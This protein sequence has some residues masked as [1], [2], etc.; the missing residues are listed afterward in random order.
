MKGERL[1]SKSRILWGKH[2]RPS[3]AEKTQAINPGDKPQA[4]EAEGCPI[5]FEREI[6]N[7]RRSPPHVHYITGKFSRLTEGTQGIPIASDL[8]DEGGKSHAQNVRRT[9]NK[10][11]QLAAEIGGLP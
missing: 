8:E 3:T 5:E 9:K 11:E 7:L 10:H 2:K 4:I 6:S 1:D